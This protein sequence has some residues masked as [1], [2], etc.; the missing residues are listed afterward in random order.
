MR[1]GWRCRGCTGCKKNPAR[2]VWDHSCLIWVPS[3]FLLVL[4][5]LQEKWLWF[6]LVT[7]QLWLPELF[8]LQRG[9]ALRESL[10]YLAMAEFTLAPF[11]R[12]VVFR[13]SWCQKGPDQPH[14]FIDRKA[15][16][17][18]NKWFL[19]G[20]IERWCQSSDHCVCLVMPP[21]MF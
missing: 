1:T 16:I 19:Q 7:E 11:D 4:P 20:L 2:E 21:Q 15:G 9:R 6:L 17:W 8:Y 12:T 10:T 3:D 18:R 14:H 5:R 13:K